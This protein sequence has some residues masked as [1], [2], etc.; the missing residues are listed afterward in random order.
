MGYFLA[1]IR[2]AIIRRLEMPVDLI[3]PLLD[4]MP[5]IREISILIPRLREYLRC[6]PPKMENPGHE[7]AACALG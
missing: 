3:L 7:K 2:D 5:C 1:K 6:R 4:D